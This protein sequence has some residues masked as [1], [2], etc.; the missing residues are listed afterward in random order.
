[1]Q[2]LVVGP[3]L[4]AQLEAGAQVGTGNGCRGVGEEHVGESRPGAAWHS[5]ACSQLPL[6]LASG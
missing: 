5:D 6:W 2:L 3:E 1:M 4:L